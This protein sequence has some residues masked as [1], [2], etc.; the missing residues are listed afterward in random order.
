MS[1]N[2]T[3]FNIR[4][5]VGILTEISDIGCVKISD[6]GWEGENKDDF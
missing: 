6:I 5:G 1:A 2:D 3:T 4:F